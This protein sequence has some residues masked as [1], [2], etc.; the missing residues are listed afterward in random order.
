M[1][2]ID[3]DTIGEI[4]IQA[5]SSG[6]AI[7]NRN[8]ITYMLRSLSLNL[9]DRANNSRNAPAKNRFISIMPKLVIVSSL[10]MNVINS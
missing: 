2:S 6:M 3:V 5:K 7:R 4:I 8:T 1:S 10:G 9:E